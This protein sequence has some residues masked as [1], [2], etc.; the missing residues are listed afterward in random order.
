MEIAT[1]TSSNMNHSLPKHANPYHTPQSSTAS[2]SYPSIYRSH[3]TDSPTSHHLMHPSHA[4]H[5]PIPPSSGQSYYSTDP[6]QHRSIPSQSASSRPS[7]RGPLNSARTLPHRHI[8][9]DQ[10]FEDAYV[11]FVLYCNPTI[12]QDVDTSDLRK[13]FSMPPRSDGKTF[14]TRVLF[15][16][17]KKFDTKEIKTWTELALELGVEKPAVDKG[18]S[19]QKVQQYS[20]RLKVSTSCILTS[21]FSFFL[22]EVASIPYA[23]FVLSEKAVLGSFA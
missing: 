17:L 6:S 9:D 11:A 3:S 7:S 20:V 14:S 5:S 15:D 12:S 19:S 16:L 22:F 13:N 2:V 21:I 8:S 18:Q 23:G 10:S 4:I 1:I